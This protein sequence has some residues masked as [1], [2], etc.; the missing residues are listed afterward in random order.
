MLS[1]NILCIVCV[2]LVM[3][4]SVS[5][6]DNTKIKHEYL[7]S[8]LGVMKYTRSSAN[9][10][11]N[12]GEVVGSLGVRS[13]ENL[14]QHSTSFLWTEKNRVDFDRSIS[15]LAINDKGEIAGVRYMGDHNGGE[16]FSVL[17]TVPIVYSNTQWKDN[18]PHEFTSGFPVAINNQGQIVGQIHPIHM[19]K[20]GF[21]PAVWSKDMA[22]LLQIPDTY[23]SGFVKSINDTG[24]IVGYVQKTSD[25]PLFQ[26]NHAV[27]W[28]NNVVTV[29]DVSLN[30][31]ESEAVA[32]NNKGCI[33]CLTTYGS[34]EFDHYV[35]ELTKGNYQ[36]EEKSL[37]FG[38][39]IYDH[40]THIALVDPKDHVVGIKT[41]AGL[42]PRAFNNFNV[43][44]GT[45]TDTNGQPT[46]FVWQNHK[47]TNLNNLVPY[48]K[49]WVLTDAKAINDRGQI[50]GQGKYNGRSRAFL[51][52]PQN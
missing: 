42:S 25:N 43:V 38:G 6:N 18:L 51:L 44:V 52:S 35:Q 24:E 15:A 12:S 9:F 3:S 20:G 16:S 31:D 46:A 37:V 40:G 28:N 41:S 1:L 13:S 8:D 4:I 48:K 14:P 11:N 2:F 47:L 32:I 22:R 19:Q 7:L 36:A 26:R 39:F 30:C 45:A 17:E 33:L 10:I 49:G 23:T 29:L 5:A 34:I 50:V 27:L 21:V